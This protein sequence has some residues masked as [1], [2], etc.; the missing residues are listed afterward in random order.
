MK[1]EKLAL[2]VMY[3]CIIAMLCRIGVSVDAHWQGFQTDSVRTI[4]KKFNVY[5]DGVKEKRTLPTNIEN[6]EKHEMVIYSIAIPTKELEETT[7]F[8]Y[9]Q[10]S[11]VKVYIN[12]TLMQQSATESRLPIFN[13]PSRWYYVSIP[14]FTY[15]TTIRIEQS[16]NTSHYA[17]ILPKVYIGTESGMFWTVVR[18][19]A[20]D[21]IVSFIL[22]LAG[23]MTFVSVSVIKDSAFCR[24]FRWMAVLLTTMGCWLVTG[25]NVWQIFTGHSMIV[26]YI[27][28]SMF[29]LLP[30]YVA[31]IL[32]SFQECRKEWYIKAG[33]WVSLVTFFVMQFGMV[34][35]W[36]H[37][38]QVLWMAQGALVF[39]MLGAA[40]SYLCHYHQGVTKEMRRSRMGI[41][42]IPICIVLDLIRFYTRPAMG[43]VLYVKYIVFI[44]C[45]ILMKNIFALYGKEQKEKTEH[46]VY[47]RLAFEDIFTGLGNRGAFELELAAIDQKKAYE[48]YIFVVDLNNLKW[49]NDHLGHRQGDDAILHTASLMK[50]C[51][52]EECLLFRM[53]GDEFCGFYENISEEDFLE[54]LRLFKQQVEKRNEEV[55]YPYSVAIGYQKKD[56]QDAES[57]F[58]RADAHMY[59]EK[60]RM[61]QSR[62]S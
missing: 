23:V 29:F 19:A 30:V 25:G 48:G 24:R 7:L 61:K 21:L 60:V 49:I 33:F 41:I 51:F 20:V 59:Q 22:I 3:I 34:T 57:C 9:A 52:G 2:V 37:Y 31:E 32:L 18:K 40:V 53:G 62:S 5:Y 1:R 8:F 46:L 56:E 47:K 45:I 28:G 14:R 38:T 13:Y 58:R 50:Q 35:Q 10:H 26:E 12:G 6:V 39:Q 36:F 4:D 55:E 44:G 11:K 16:S 27:H 17:G 42:L 54:K 43:S 15:T